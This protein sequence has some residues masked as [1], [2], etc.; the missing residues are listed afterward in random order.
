MF[1]PN[2]GK[3]LPDEARFCPICGH[4]IKAAPGAAEPARA[5]APVPEKKKKKRRKA[6]LIVALVLI[7][8]LVLGAGGAAAWVLLRGPDGPDP[9]SNLCSHDS[10]VRLDQAALLNGRILRS[11]RDIS[12]TDYWRVM[13]PD[14][15]GGYTPGKRLSAG[16]LY[17]M[18]SFG[19]KAYGVRHADGYELVRLDPERD[20]E[21]IVYRSENSLE[22][23]G[24][25]NDRLWFAE[26][27]QWDTGT[28]TLR[29]LDQNGGMDSLSLGTV[30][31]LDQ[32]VVTDSGVYLNSDRG[33]TLLDF[34]GEPAHSFAG[35]DGSQGQGFLRET[36][37]YLYLVLSTGNG[38][39]TRIVRADKKTYETVDIGMPIVDSVSDPKWFLNAFD[40]GNGYMYCLYMSIDGAGQAALCRV[41]ERGEPKV[42]VMKEF[43]LGKEDSY[44]GENDVQLY[45]LNEERFWIYGSYSF[46]AGR[47]TYWTE[48]TFEPDRSLKGI[49]SRLWQAI[50]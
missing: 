5:G 12:Y 28:L 30:E 6:P 15:Q 31:E 45:M 1:C 22:L 14:G 29:S 19:G 49:A 42:E 11:E 41:S 9:W 43:S 37:K 17:T 26:Y 34:T 18:T 8:A 2:C 32:L 10:F 20:A 23:C 21:D 38:M 24:V 39:D 4:A 13:E 47:E 46:P 25:V 27:D 44:L 48:L 36:D 50:T 16:D 33:F 3:Q 7:L 40:F 35:L